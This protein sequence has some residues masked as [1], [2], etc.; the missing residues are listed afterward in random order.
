MGLNLTQYA[1]PCTHAPGPL[2]QLQPTQPAYCMCR[3]GRHHWRPLATQFGR[4]TCAKSTNQAKPPACIWTHMCQRQRTRSPS[5][6]R[7]RCSSPSRHTLS[8]LSFNAMVFT[9]SA[10]SDC[11]YSCPSVSQRPSGL[12]CGNT[13][14]NPGRVTLRR[15]KQVSILSCS[16]LSSPQRQRTGAATQHIVEP[17]DNRPSTHGQL[18]PCAHLDSQT[19]TKLQT[20]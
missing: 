4:G 12:K 8:T 16:A 10:F 15:P 5:L 2:D 14:T 7:M 9:P 17:T 19:P 13:C 20:R 6:R 3:E 18:R 1:T 11:Y